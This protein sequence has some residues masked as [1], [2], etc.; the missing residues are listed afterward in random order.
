MSGEEKSHEV[1]NSDDSRW[2]LP[3]IKSER[4]KSTTLW[5]TEKLEATNTETME[6]LATTTPAFTKLA[7]TLTSNYNISQRLIGCLMLTQ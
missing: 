7:V 3:F 1:Y 5:I 4:Q 2:V 6:L